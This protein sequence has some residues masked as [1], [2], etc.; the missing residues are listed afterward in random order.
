[1]IDN[2]QNNEKTNEIIYLDNFNQAFEKTKEKLTEAL[3]STP[4]HI[5]PYT[6]H[7]AKAQGKLIRAASLLACAVNGEGRINEEAVYAAVGVELLHLATLVHDDVI[8]DAGTRRGISTLNKQY[9]RKTAV[10][11][12]DYLLCLA[13]EQGK[14]LKQR[15]I[16]LNNYMTQICLGE[17][18]QHENNFNF[19]LSPIKYFRI[20]KGK[21]AAL[22]EA[23]FFAG[24]V[25]SDE[26]KKNY[27]IYSKMG[28]YLGM[29]FQ[30]IDDCI[31]FEV[32]E[33]VAKKPVHSDFEQGVITMPMIHALSYDE[34]LAEMR[35]KGELN[36]KAIIDSVRR[37]G[38]IFYTKGIAKRYYNKALKYLSLIGISEEKANRIKAIFD[39]AYNG[40]TGKK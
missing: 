8:D 28:N 21:T 13:L 31:D 29:I 5:R 32:D 38:S 19:M 15:D 2:V 12:G 40:L 27:H 25:L 34:K 11:C 35:K 26:D 7:L 24:A 33:G 17:L 3:K 37:Y 39:K 16:E 1:M 9:D 23:S 4:K 36:S 10:I 30:L 6:S 14:N 20:I 22:F 18:R